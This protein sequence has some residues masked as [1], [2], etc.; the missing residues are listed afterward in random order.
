MRRLAI[1]TTHPIQYYAPVFQLLAKE[2]ELKVFYSGG[3]EGFNKYDRAFKADISWDIPLLQGYDYEFLT[4]SSRS[5]G[6]HHFFGVINK[7]AVARI[8]QYKPTAL[9]VYGWANLSHINIL[10]HFHGKTPIFFRGDSRL[11]DKEPFYK[12]I[13]K[14][15][16]LNWVYKH[17]STAF[18]VGTH[19]KAYFKKFGMKDSQ[20]VFAPHAI[21][22]LRFQ[23]ERSAEAI[24]LRHELGIPPEAIV[25][26]FA[27]KLK[28]I[29]NPGILLQAFRLINPSN[30]HLMIVGS[31]EL[32]LEVEAHTNGSARRN[33]HLLPFQNQSQMPVLYQTCDLFCM[34]TKH[35]GETWGLAVNE[36]MASAKAIMTSDQVGSACD[37]VCEHNGLVFKSEN[38]QDL[39][40]KLTVLLEDKQALAKMGEISIKKI[41]EWSIEKQVQQILAHV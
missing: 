40:K 31:G 10:R 39:K 9:L 6:S 20:L 19:N 35:P 33:I 26:L 24:A 30:A 32:Q 27:G 41:A 17:V 34:P 22:N 28:N 38:L 21:D 18:Y 5:P 36:A 37:L 23:E 1:I 25:L 14:T 4:N 15:A 2:I 12:R 29:K 7:D 8:R 11:V 3:K 16:L 13:I